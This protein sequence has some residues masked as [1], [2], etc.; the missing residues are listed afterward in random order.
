MRTETEIEKKITLK[1]KSFSDS[2]FKKVLD[3]EI[4]FNKCKQQTIS[5]IKKVCYYFILITDSD[6]VY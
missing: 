6:V 5:M 2:N 4:A 1:Q 3:F